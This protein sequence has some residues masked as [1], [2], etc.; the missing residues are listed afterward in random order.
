M[1]VAADMN[2]YDVSCRPK[3]VLLAACIQVVCVLLVAGCA[4]ESDEDDAITA[5][6]VDTA[7][8]VGSESQRC[9]ETQSKADDW[10]SEFVWPTEHSVSIWDE[11]DAAYDTLDE[12][13]WSWKEDVSDT[14][15]ERIDTNTEVAANA[16]EE[17]SD[18]FYEWI[19][20]KL[21]DGDKQ[22]ADIIARFL[23]AIAA[24]AAATINDFEASQSD[25]DKGDQIIVEQIE[26][27]SNI[28]T[29]AEGHAKELRAAC[30]L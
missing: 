16:Y 6:K 8:S 5:S 3:R 2:R 24:D 20:E 22:F 15:I 7:V 17:A 19:A 27:W 30:G 23:D 14:E 10:I 21:F 11:L 28:E 9:G 18:E 1:S 13:G 12:E 4:G 29:E 25:T 26:I